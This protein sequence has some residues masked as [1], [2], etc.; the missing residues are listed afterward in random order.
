MIVYKKIKFFISIFAVDLDKSH[1][2][3]YIL[4]SHDLKIHNLIVLS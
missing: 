4:Y 1:R 2:Q 3:E